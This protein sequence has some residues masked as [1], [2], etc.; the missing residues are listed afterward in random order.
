MPLS[1]ATMLVG[2]VVELYMYWCLAI[3]V[4][5]VLTIIIA[6][7]VLVAL[8]VSFRSLISDLVLDYN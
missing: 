8:F 4:V 5:V 1:I 6:M 7:K 3:L 2:L